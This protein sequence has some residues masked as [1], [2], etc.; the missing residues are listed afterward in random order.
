M[1]GSD[2][3]EMSINIAGEIINLKVK[4]DD[5]LN[6]REVEREVNL[7]LDKMRKS[8]EEATNRELLAMTAYHFADWYLQLNK[9]QQDA[10]ELTNQK[11]RQIDEWDGKAESDH[12]A[13][14]PLS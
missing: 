5:Q 10:I 12:L 8:N 3:V 2:L 14:P 1:K 9:I 13:Y 6:V 4:F 11:C 7:Y